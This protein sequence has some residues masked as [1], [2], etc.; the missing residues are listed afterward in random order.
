MR[1]LALASVAFVAFGASQALA[2][3]MPA[4]APPVPVVVPFSWTGFYI[5]LN[6][7]GA[8]SDRDIGY[9]LPPFTSGVVATCGAPAGVAL[10]APTTANLSATCSDGSSFTG[11]GQIGYNWQTGAFVLGVEGDVMWRD[12]DTVQFTRFGTN[13]TAG[14]PMGSVATDTAYHRS[15]QGTVGTVRARLGY[16][17]DRWLLYITGGVAVGETSASVIEVLAPGNACPAFGATCRGASVSDTRVGY[18]VGGGF[19]WAFANNWS[20]G[21]EYLFIDLGTTDITLTPTGGFFSNTSV[22]S[23]DHQS[24]TARAKL[25]YR[26][27]R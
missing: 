21:A 17:P 26:F 5:G 15:N 9:S 19:E 22:S 7:G 12:L 20:V 3:D 14:A 8:W 11:G 16:A 18:A 27:G 13:T 6:A 10:P 4:K 24:H 23:F 25:N 1:A 2:A